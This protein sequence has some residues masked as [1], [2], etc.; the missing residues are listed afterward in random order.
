MSGRTSIWVLG[1]QLN[2]GI[3]A[4]A[5]ADPATDSVLMIESAATLRRPFHRQRRHFV[6]A[7]MRKFA[8]ELSRSGFDV[9][10]RR[11]DT[12][13]AGVEAHRADHRGREVVATEPNSRE[14]RSTAAR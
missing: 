12:I 14:A 13:R 2:R 5:D 9:D 10:Y 8:A 3:G 11:A 6:L 7:S 1:D 4:L